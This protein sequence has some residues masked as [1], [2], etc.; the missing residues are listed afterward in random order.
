MYFYYSSNMMKNI[1]T[2]I[3]RFAK[4]E[5]KILGRWNI[6]QTPK[7]INSK[8][9]WSNED[10][11]GPCGQYSIDKTTKPISSGPLKNNVSVK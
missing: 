1:V 11:C 7:Q 3:K 9:D 2:F 5:P 6:D 10:H 8:V 4:T